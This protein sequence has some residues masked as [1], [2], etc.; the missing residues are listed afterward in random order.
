MASLPGDPWADLFV[1]LDQDDVAGLIDNSYLRMNLL[2]FTLHLTCTY[3]SHPKLLPW[4]HYN[5]AVVGRN[6][7]A[8]QRS[9]ETTEV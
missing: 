4:R 6:A 2:D 3:S 5:K 9:Q 1:K 8:F 7:T